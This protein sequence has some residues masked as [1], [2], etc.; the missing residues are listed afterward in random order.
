MPFIVSG[1]FMQ[2]TDENNLCIRI[3]MSFSRLR[4]TM[5]AKL[6]F[7]LCIIPVVLLQA[8]NPDSIIIRSIEQKA[9]TLYQ[10]NPDSVKKVANDTILTG[11]RSLLQKPSSISFPFDSLKFVKA[12]RPSDKSFLLITWTV[13]FADGHR[14]Y[15]FLQINGSSEIMEVIELVDN[16]GSMKPNRSY[17]ATDWPGAVYYELIEKSTKTGKLFILFGWIGGEPG[18]ARR[19]IEVLTFDEA[20]NPVFGAPVF[21]MDQNMLQYRV[22]FEFTDQVPFHLAYEE[23]LIPGTRS[24]K[25]RMIIF[26][27][28]TGNDP[29]RGRFYRAA[30]PSYNTFDA[31]IFENGHWQLHKDVDARAMEI[32]SPEQNSRR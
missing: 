8:S 9:L 24:K 12:V 17:P 31:L 15:G 3:V 7:F 21:Q 1:R 19:V 14:Y 11:M 32:S 26:N 16:D 5:K 30:V 20:G 28:L 10:N 25:G 4:K 2:V 22:N 23:Q 13:P 27:R 6:L 29:A 18:T